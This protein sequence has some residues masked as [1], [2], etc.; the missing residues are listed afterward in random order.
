M[1]G[2]AVGFPTGR[3]GS[4]LRLLGLHGIPAVVHTRPI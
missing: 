1:L 4:K 2:D 3:C